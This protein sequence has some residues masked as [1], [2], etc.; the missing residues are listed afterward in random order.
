M[1]IEI[2]CAISMLR[3]TPGE[4]ATLLGIA[5]ILHDNVLV[6]GPTRWTLDAGR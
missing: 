2:S 1:T 3:V 5:A 4:V 6:P